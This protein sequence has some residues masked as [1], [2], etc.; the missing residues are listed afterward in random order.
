MRP[1]NLGVSQG[2]QMVYFQKNLN[3]GKF[4]EDLGNGWYIL[5]PFELCY[6]SLLHLMVIW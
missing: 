6:Y 3:L 2:C 5:W 4:L 1:I